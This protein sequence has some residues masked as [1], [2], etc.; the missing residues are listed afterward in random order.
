MRLARQIKDRTSR[1]L[2]YYVY[3]SDAKLEML[4][5]QIDPG[6]RKRISAELKVDL[7]IASLTLR[8]ADSVTQ[9]REGKLK[10]VERFIRTYHDVGTIQ[11]PDG[12]YFYGRMNMRWG[13]YGDAVLFRSVSTPAESVNQSN[14][15]LVGSRHHVIGDEAPRG[16]F[17]VSTLS[18]RIARS[19]SSLSQII[20]SFKFSFETAQEL[21]LAVRSLLPPVSRQYFEFLAVEL[22]SEEESYQFGDESSFVLG[23]PIFVAL[24][25]K[26]PGA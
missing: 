22:L 9:T 14:V 3:I 25:R 13:Y 6:T 5:G 7:K 24:A 18:I 11:K 1:S 17:D 15:L 26:K 8:D 19:I 16:G 10:I 4:Y 2:R 20:V 23:T 21:Y 12:E